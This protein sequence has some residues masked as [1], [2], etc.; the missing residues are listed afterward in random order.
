[1]KSPSSSSSFET[2]LRFAAALL[3]CLP[4]IVAA[5]C[6]AHGHGAM[7]SPGLLAVITACIAAGAAGSY[8][9][10]QMIRPRTG[11]I[12]PVASSSTL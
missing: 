7:G 11:A 10:L 12:A 9:L 1:M 8:P 6:F 4:A 5:A 3:L 2:R